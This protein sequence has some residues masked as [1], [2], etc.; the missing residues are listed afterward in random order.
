MAQNPSVPAASFRGYVAQ[1]PQRF[2]DPTTII[3]K[4]DALMST[5]ISYANQ[6]GTIA[7]GLQVPVINPV[8]PTI[9][10]APL[11]ITVPPPVTKEVVWTVPT[12]P[13][14]NYGDLGNLD[15]Y[16]PGPLTDLPPTLV[17]GTVPPKDFGSAPDSPQI[18]LNFTL[19]ELHLQLPTAPQLMTINTIQ[20]DGVTLPTFDTTAPVLNVVAPNLITYQEAPPYTSTLL[21]MLKQDLEDAISNGLNIGMPTEALRGLFD[22]ARENEYRTMADSLAELDRMEAMGFALPPGVYV[23]GRIKITTETQNKM[24]GLNRDIMVKQADLTLQNLMKCREDATQLEGK[25]IDYA[26]QVAQR[27]FE[28]SKYQ[29]EALVAIYNARINAFN[30]Q[31]EG[32]KARAQ[33]YDYQI[34]GALAI[35][36]IYKT[37]VEAES[38]KAQVNNSLV[39][40]YKAEVDAAMANVE[41]FKAELQAVQ[42]QA[43]LQ[44]TKVEAFAEQIRA[45]T[46]QISAYSAEVE[47]YKAT[48]QAQ[49]IQQDAYRSRVEAYKATVEAGVAQINGRVEGYKAKITGYQASLDGFKASLEAMVQQARAAAEYNTSRAEV[50]RATISGISA[51]NEVITKQWSAAIEIATKQ[52]ELGIKAAEANIQAYLQAKQIAIEAAKTGAQVAA[53]LGA[54]AFNAISFSNSNS[55]SS[56]GSQSYAESYSYALSNSAAST[57]SYSESKSV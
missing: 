24:A 50:Y 1:N 22:Q 16:L 36:E 51:Y 39:Q 14:A 28:S 13:G 37:R 12:Q 55:W 31:M 18:D 42:I 34:R 44:K 26:N 2:G 11:P 5:A 21:S 52:T 33:V 6:I 19:P 3:S 54:A 57:D 38:L 40:M 35:A 27:A 53:Q 8:F 4:G 20:F 41:I 17:F 45:Y 15:G 48:M 30:A 25:L 23:D 32:Y 43:E 29:T 46:G 56:S 10:S 47:A 9:G 49:G 7:G